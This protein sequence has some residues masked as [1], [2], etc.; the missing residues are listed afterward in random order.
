MRLLV[1]EMLAP[2]IARELCARGHDV[3]AI[4]EH[5]EW[6]GRSDVEVMAFAREQ[7]RALVTNNLRDFRPL[8]AAAL[9]EGEGH[10]GMVFVP[11]AYR[12]TRAD[13]G[14]LVA[15]LETQLAAYPDEEDLTDG[16][17]WL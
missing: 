15:A 7:R 8:H 12:R 4:K 1:D 13:V 11:S 3:V 17:T 10:F 5:A 16:E 2:A 9:A 6:V 14:R